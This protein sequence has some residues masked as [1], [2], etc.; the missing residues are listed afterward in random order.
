MATLDFSIPA[1]QAYKDRT[2][3]RALKLLD[4]QL[5]K[6]GEVL[7]G[8]G[9][10]RQYLAFN[11]AGYEREV[12]SALWLDAQH[13]L[14][15]AEHLAIGTLTQTSVY[16]REV[17][18]R[19]LQLNAAAVIFAHNHPSGCAEPSKADLM[20]TQ[21]L[22]NTLALVDVRVLDHFIVAGSATTSLE[23]LGLLGKTEFPSKEAQAEPPK[24]DTATAKQDLN[25]PTPITIGFEVLTLRAHIRSAF[26]LLQLEDDY[27]S[28]E[29]LCDVGFALIDADSKLN[30]IHARVDALNVRGAS[31]FSA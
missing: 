21:V 27:E 7:N 23:E 5:R 6:P 12:F 25:K 3:S 15:A 20:L 9:A 24:T 26:A 29:T 11:L 22:M 31:N 16:P 10:V 30:E 2:I 28:N 19:C 13:R 8:T 18:K 1:Q 4:A 17:V 14:I